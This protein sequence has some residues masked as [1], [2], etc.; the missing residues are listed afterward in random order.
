MKNT[1]KPNKTN[2]QIYK[3]IPEWE[4]G[5]LADVVEDF[6]PKPKDLIRSKTVRKV[7]IELS[8]E[9]I[10]FFKKEAQ[11]HNTSY[12]PMIRNLLDEYVRAMNASKY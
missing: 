8:N 2:N 6:L 11:K 4:D 9:S 1:K 10:A 5:F 12:Q 3:D 7:T